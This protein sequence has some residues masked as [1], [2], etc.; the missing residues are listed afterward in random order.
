ME[1]GSQ[2]WNFVSSKHSIGIDLNIAL[3]I[4]LKKKKAIR[5]H[6]YPLLYV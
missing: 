1:T 5:L 4:Y 2:T 3:V 6:R